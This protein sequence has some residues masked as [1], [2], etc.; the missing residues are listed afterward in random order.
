MQPITIG[1]FEG[2][3]TAQGVIRPKDDSWQLVID[4]QGYPRLY[5]RVKLE[6]TTPTDPAT[7]MVSVEE[8]FN[9]EL[10]LTI[11]VL[12]QSTFGGELTEAEQNEA[13]QAFLAKRE[14]DP[15]PCPR[16]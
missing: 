8:F 7:G 6:Q 12:M 15:R 14:T 10:E 2:D 9:P 11:P 13:Y 4:A 3:E 16:D 5:V 1:R